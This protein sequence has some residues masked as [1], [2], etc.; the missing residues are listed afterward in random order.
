MSPGI[1]SGLAG[2]IPHPPRAG[3]GAGGTATASAATLTELFMSP[4]YTTAPLV[5]VA[6]QQQQQ[7][8][9]ALAVAQAAQYRQHQQHQL[10]VSSA[11]GATNA[12]RQQQLQQTHEQ[13]PGLQPVGEPVARARTSKKARA[14][15]GALPAGIML[16]GAIGGGARGVAAAELQAGS[17]VEEAQR[18]AALKA[19]RFADERKQKRA[20]EATI[21]KRPRD[22]GS[23]AGAT[24][25]A[26]VSE[27]A[28]GNGSDDAGPSDADANLPPDELRKKRYLRRLELNRQSAAVSRVRRREYVKELEDKLV[29]VEKEKYR[30][31]GQV[32]SMGNENLKLRAQMKALQAQLG[33]P[34]AQA[35]TYLPV[36]GAGSSGRRGGGSRK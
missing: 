4:E 11:V 33:R 29:G 10:F 5:A 12:G 25:D 17:A 30:L 1:S 16:G 6:Q 36:N 21:A 22:D 13:Q 15:S 7:S 24:G 8:G 18:A 28:P 3:A 31:Q 34:P 32:D 35:G 14:V 19:E 9:S 23:G 2:T 26:D 27:D 20:A